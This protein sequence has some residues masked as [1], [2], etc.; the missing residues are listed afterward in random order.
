MVIINEEYP[1]YVM[2]IGY[3]P[4]HNIQVDSKYPL[5]FRNW[6]NGDNQRRI[7]SLRNGYWIFLFTQ[8]SVTNYLPSTIYKGK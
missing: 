8:R 1:H 2:D 7:S 6:R 5:L 3:F 4:C